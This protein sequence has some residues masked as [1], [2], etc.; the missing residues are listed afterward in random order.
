[1]LPDEAAPPV[2]LV[3][4]CD[5]ESSL[6]T[7]GALRVASLNMNGAASRAMAD[8]LSNSRSKWLLINQ[9]L[10]QQRTGILALQETHISHEQAAELNVLYDG[11]MRVFVSPDPENPSAARGVAFAINLRVCKDDAVRIREL[12]PGRAVELSLTRRRGTRLAILNVYAPTN[13][14]ESAGFWSALGEVYLAQRCHPPD[15]MLGDFNVV[16][17]ALDR[18]PSR[19]DAPRAA[20][21]LTA[22]LTRW[23]LMD[24]WRARNGTSRSFSYLQIA[25]GSQSRID[26][27]YAKQALVSMAHSWEILPAGIPTDHSLVSAAFADYNEPA[28]GPGRWRIPN[29]LLSDKMFLEEAQS[30]GAEMALRQYTDCRQHRPAQWRL[31]ELKTALLAVARKRAKQLTPKLDKR[32]ADLG[33][34]AQ[35]ALANTSVPVKDREDEAALLKDEEAR[36]AMRRFCQQRNR[37]HMKDGLL[38]ETLSRYWVRL[39]TLPEVQD[40]IYELRLLDGEDVAHPRYTRDSKRM[41]ETA[42]VFYDTLQDDPGMCTVDHDAAVRAVLAVEIPVLSAAQGDVLDADLSWMDVELAL[43]SSALNKAPGLDGIPAELWIRLHKLYLAKSRRNKPAF[44]VVTMMMKAF[45]EAAH[46]GVAP[47]SNFAK[48]W[49]CPIYK[50]KGDTRE[51]SSYRP[52]TIL[53]SDYKVMTK[54]LA[55]R[56]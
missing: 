5:A 17:S 11:L 26:R 29:L 22:L 4:Q 19:L 46:L 28:S 9:L 44:N 55:A 42:K 36:L 7:R 2:P 54:V 33:A 45:N 56:L 52:I 51:A 34:A 16:E 49:V 25:T 8:G 43:L 47:A 24:G 6:R 3:P 38:G 21:A 1:M 18:A 14:S 10:R 41:A 23:H 13:M 37:A 32:I 12:V 30:L 35:A 15:I 50:L 39:H 27:I 40:P 53:N 20:D 31:C 48:G